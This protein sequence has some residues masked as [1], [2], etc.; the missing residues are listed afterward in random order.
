MRLSDPPGRVSVQN[1]QTHII[2]IAPKK[3]VGVCYGNAM[4]VSVAV[5]G[6]R[7]IYVQR[8]KTANA[9]KLPKYNPYWTLQ[10]HILRR[11]I[12]R[13][14]RKEFEINVFSLH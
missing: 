4:E 10:I 14:C 2:V 7:P 5:F 1:G 9:A 6:P 13:K 11:P 3:F 8:W 12:R